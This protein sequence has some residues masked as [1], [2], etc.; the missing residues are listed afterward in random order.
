MRW[1]IA[2]LIALLC[3]VITVV[4]AD[5]ITQFTANVAT[6]KIL[7]NGQETNFDNPPV[8]ING[9]TYLPLRSIAQALGVV[10]N[11]NAQLN[12]VEITQP[13]TTTSNNISVDPNA[14]SRTNP[15]PLNTSQNI[16]GSGCTAAVTV[17]DIIRG[18]EALSIINSS[19]S[20]VEPNLPSGYDFLL[21]KLKVTLVNSTNDTP[22]TVDGSS[23]TLFSSTGTS[24]NSN[25][26]FANCFLPATYPTLQGEIYTGGSTEGWLCYTVAFDDSKPVLR[27]GDTD[28]YYWFAVYK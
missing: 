13:T 21:I 3:I 8:A 10:V 18:D 15:A 17:E 1:K 16:N 12:Q 22:L 9:R 27:I 24:Y 25:N 20:S 5:D 7:I 23:M 11:W 4:Y 28:P 26:I 14:Y 19:N 2:I 6:F